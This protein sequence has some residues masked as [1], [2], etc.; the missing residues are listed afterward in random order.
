MPD[1]RT[2]AALLLILGPVLGAIPV[3]NPRLVVIWSMSRDEHVATVRANRRGWRLIN[4]GFV[5]AT[6]AT[7]AGLAILAL[8]ADGGTGVRAGL[9]AGATAYWFGG[10]LWCAVLAARAR[11]TPAIADLV[12]AGSAD[13]PAEALL[14]A[15]MEGLFQAFVLITA[16]ALIVIGLALVA[17]GLVAAMVAWF[18]VV[19][20][21]AAIVILLRTGDLIPALLY[22]CT[23]LIG[24]A[25]LAGWA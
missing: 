1:D 21:I 3:G 18:A 9:L 25:L 22:P 13:T 11:T 12:A 16:V 14:G 17:G 7:S 10:L 20:A 2:I 4:A 23:V 6:V 5:L 19:T 8:E 15:A 24:V